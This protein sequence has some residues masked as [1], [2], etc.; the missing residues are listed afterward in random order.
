LSILVVKPGSLTLPD[1]KKLRQIGIV[2]VEAEDPASVKLISP[3]GPAL[4]ANDMLFAAMSAIAKDRYSGNTQEAFVKLAV[5]LMEQ[6]RIGD[7]P[8]P[9]GASS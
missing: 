7:A 3:E 1:R 2:A 6:V 4:G 9:D 5:K 8:T